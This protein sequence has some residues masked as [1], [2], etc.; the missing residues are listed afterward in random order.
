MRSRKSV[1]KTLFIF[2]FIGLGIGCFSSAAGAQVKLTL[3]YPAGQITSG[4]APFADKTI[5]AEFEAKNKCKVEALEGNYDTLMQKIMTAMVGGDVPDILFIDRSWLPGFLKEEVLDVVPA[6]D[7]KSWLGQVSPEIVE[8]SDYGQGKMYGYPQYGVQVYGITW[9]KDHFKTAGLDPEKPPQTWAELRQYSAK[10]RKAD[11]SGNITRVG[12]A[13]RHVGHP[14]GVVHKF[15]WGFWAGG[16]ELAS[17]SKALRGGRAK[18]NTEGVRDALKLI[19]DMIYVDKSTS[20]NFPDPRD[21][22]LQGIASMQISETI[23]IQ[24]R[25][26]KEAPTLKW[27]VAL[28]PVRKAGDSPVTNL[29]TWFYCVP[30]KTKNKALAWKAIQFINSVEKDYELC[31]ASNSTPRYKVNWSKEPFVSDPFNQSLKK[32]LPYGRPYPNNLGLN[33]IMEALGAAI[34]KVW[35]NEAKIEVALAEAEALANKAITEAAR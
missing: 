34:Q 25:A 32:M 4:V 19:Y 15:L 16:G 30:T 2:S 26:P 9:N 21:A 29:N 23:A 13:I 3:W 6:A 18:F 24:G 1:F 31:K 28:P 7:A 14:H 35:H 27:G 17:D 10:L 20:L 8:L 12:L 11:A 5:F 33:G 22:F